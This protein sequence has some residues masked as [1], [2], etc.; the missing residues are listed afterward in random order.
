MLKYK[1][2]QTLLLLENEEDI[3]NFVKTFGQQDPDAPS[4]E[5]PEIATRLEPQGPSPPRLSAAR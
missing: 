2:F 1:D 4:I 3:L 5:E